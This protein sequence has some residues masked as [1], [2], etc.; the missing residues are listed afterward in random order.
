M[1]SSNFF[2]PKQLAFFIFGQAGPA[3]QI[4]KALIVV[5]EHKKVD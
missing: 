3:Q 1:N 4:S 5:F 2:V